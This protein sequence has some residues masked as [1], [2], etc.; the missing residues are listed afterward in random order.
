[1]LFL[2][3]DGGTY[4]S[5]DRGAT[6]QNLTETGLPNAQFYATWSS[7][8]EPDLF[9]AGSQDQGLQISVPS[10]GARPGAPLFNQ[11]LISGDYGNLTAAT[12]D[13]T[14][15]YAIYPTFPPNPG[16]VL[17]FQP[18]HWLRGE[19]PSMVFAPLPAMA[20]AGFYAA[21]AADPDDPATLYVGGDFIWRLRHRG[22]GTFAQER[23]PQSFTSG[24]SDYVA[25]LAIAPSDSSIWYAATF[26]GRLWYSRDRGATWTQSDTTRAAPPF[27]S[28]TSLLVAADDPFTCYAGGSGYGS[29]P[30][31]VTRDGG[32]TWEPLDR[33][34]PSTLV[35]ALAFDNP[36]RQKLYAATEAGPFVFDA[37]V[38]RSLLGGG[39]PVARYYSV[40]GVPAAGV[41]RFGTFSRGVWDYVVPR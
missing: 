5:F 22:D 9:L 29:P 32:V 39:A 16:S 40:E 15:V 26:L 31:V 8:S 27:T 33:G 18:Q 23:V 3:T 21:A 38:W 19:P 4:Q 2:S 10:G 24:G 30:V 35:W 28:T 12:H 7:G 11:Q 34:M 14:D 13:M 6:V 1:M 37:G 20:R 17:I 41:V 25:S 36:T